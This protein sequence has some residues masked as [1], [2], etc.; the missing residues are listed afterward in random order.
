MGW[1]EKGCAAAAFHREGIHQRIAY[2]Q[3]QHDANISK[4][5]LDEIVNIM[6][7]TLC[8]TNDTMRISGN[9]YPT[10]LVQE[11]FRQIDSIHIQYVFQQLR[12]STSKVGNIKRYLLTT[13]FNAPSTIDNFYASE[14]NHNYGALTPDAPDVPDMPDDF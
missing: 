3:L 5:R 13:L 7:E 10:A 11:R 8:A 2:D 4:S 12:Q 9:D 6:V 14:V 1:D